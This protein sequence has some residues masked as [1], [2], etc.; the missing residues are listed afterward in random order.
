[1]SDKDKISRRIAKLLRIAKRDEGNQ[2][3][4]AAR[5]ADELMREHKIKVV[6]PPSDE[7]DYEIRHERI[8]P[9][10]RMWVSSLAATLAI[11]HG[12]NAYFDI[13]PITFGLLVLTGPT[14]RLDALQTAMERYRGQFDALGGRRASP[15]FRFG[16]A[17][18]VFEM[19]E[20][21]R[22]QAQRRE[23][24]RMREQEEEPEVGV[25]FRREHVQA[26]PEPQAQE[27]RQGTPRPHGTGD[28]S[29]SHSRPEE[30]PAESDD[31]KTWEEP[32]IDRELYNAGYT[33]MRQALGRGV[34]VLRHLGWMFK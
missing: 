25:T 4:T 33:A 1:M 28:P 13:R 24:A 17:I 27:A 3:R 26:D 7:R 2:G 31:P 18:A 34:P 23:R 22:E 32:P 11:Q 9:S 30:D 16:C 15:S 21:Q 29:E 14:M 10:E 5:I 20:E 6:L 12:C 19:Y 8:V